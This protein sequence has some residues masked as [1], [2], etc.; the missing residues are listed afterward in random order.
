MLVRIFGLVL[1]FSAAFCVGAC[2]TNVDFPPPTPTA[3]SGGGTTAATT[4]AVS[5]VSSGTASNSSSGAG[6]NSSSSSSGSGGAGGKWTPKSLSG[7]ALWLDSDQGMVQ[8]PTKPGYLLRWLDSSG[9]GNKGELAVMPQSSFMALDSAVLNGHTAVKCIVN[10][11][12]V[13]HAPSLEWGT[14]DFA[15]GVVVRGDYQGGLFKTM[16]WWFKDAQLGSA[17]VLNFDKSKNYV[18]SAGVKSI[19][20]LPKNDPTGVK[21]HIVI[22]RGNTMRLAVDDASGSAGMAGD[23]GNAGADVILCRPGDQGAND[24]EVAEIVAVKGTV[25]DGDVAKLQSYWKT[26]FG[27]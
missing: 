20:A 15:M 17:L 24:F 2:G 22:A 5:A 14:G 11:L 1:S 9:N 6:G 12:N 10:G 18:L 8:V 23:V 3:T 13:G 16:S 25:S 26:K 19:M 21:F 27:L 4:T 7:L